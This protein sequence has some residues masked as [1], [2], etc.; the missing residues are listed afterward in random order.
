MGYNDIGYNNDVIQTP[1]ID[2]FSAKGTR[3]TNF[4]THSLCT[5]SRSALLTG[6]YAFRSGLSNVLV[7]SP[8]FGLDNLTFPM[9][10]QQ[11][12]YRTHYVGKWHL[13]AIDTKYVP[14]RLG[15]DTFFGLY[16]GAFDHTAHDSFEGHGL[17]ND[18]TPSRQFNGVHAT[19]LF[20][21]EA[22]RIV[23]QEQARAQPYF[24]M[25]SYTA[26]HDPVQSTYSCGITNWYR[27]TYC[28]MLR[29]LDEQ[30]Q[31]I[32]EA[33]SPTT[34]VIFTSDNGG[35]PWAGG[36]NH[37]YRGLKG[38]PYEG[39][40]KVPAF[41]VGP[42]VPSL[43]YHSRFFITDWFRTI[44][45][46]ANIASSNRL[47][48]KSVH[49]SEDR[50][51]DFKRNH[52]RNKSSIV[53]AYEPFT[54]TYSFID[55]RYKLIMVSEEIDT[56]YEE[57]RSLMRV[58]TT[59]HHHILVDAASTIFDTIVRLYGGHQFNYYASH[60]I[61]RAIMLLFVNTKPNQTP[62]DYFD[63]IRCPPLDAESLFIYVFDLDE[64]PMETHD[65]SGT[66][67]LTERLHR[68]YC[69]A[70]TSTDVKQFVGYEFYIMGVKCGINTMN[71]MLSLWHI[72]MMIPTV[73]FLRRHHSFL[74]IYVMLYLIS[75][76][77][78]PML[79]YKLSERISFFGFMTA[80]TVYSYRA[81]IKVKQD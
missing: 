15:F 17:Y 52:P 75:M 5:P 4:Y 50:L 34:Y 69:E 47:I 16:G 13:G 22:L 9:V 70:L 12:H 56:Y 51:S 79:R 10:L 64:D 65:L 28:G 33:I 68:S 49:D 24:M 61:R 60:L 32:F 36:N 76:T 80:L 62:P 3:F 43:T 39:G 66:R 21:M 77:T 2:A 45:S 8:S 14:Q 27:D 54:H 31:T 35:Y 71:A 81:L 58:N 18:T 1:N 46:M 29:E 63:V 44:L 26:P 19:R 6:N 23:H 40:V 48:Q 57:P 30:L 67:H 59:L 20:T 25:L 53:L 74:R 55:Q 42:S 11:N 38:M 37:P 73:V 72:A 7:S 78:Q 41:M